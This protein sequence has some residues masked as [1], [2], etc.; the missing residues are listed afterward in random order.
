MRWP[1]LCGVVLLCWSARLCAEKCQH[2]Q[3]CV[4]CTSSVNHTSANLSC[5]WLNCK[6]SESRCANTS[7][8][9]KHCLAVNET[10]CE[11]PVSTTA[12]PTL[13]STT[14]SSN[15]S[16][17][18][19]V[20]TTAV[21]IPASTTNSSNSSTSATPTPVSTMV[22]L[23]PNITSLTTTA[24]TPNGT[25]LAPPLPHKKSTF[26]AASFIGGIVLVLGLQAV[27]FFAVKF[28][29]TKDR[30]YHTL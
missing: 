17:S 16:T 4:N 24:G 14:N 20:S 30:N 23:T 3:D 11:A 9:P 19:P 5:I 1:V 28:C 29:K 6:D 13:A 25:T 21:P 22:T 7:L 15:S 18:A 12:V 10:M 27:I 26:D 2:F 8:I